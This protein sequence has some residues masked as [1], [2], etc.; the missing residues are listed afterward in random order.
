[1]QN[2]PMLKRRTLDDA[3]TIKME[4]T[5]LNEL[6]QLKSQHGFDYPEWV[7]AMVREKLPEVAKKLKNTA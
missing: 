2:L 5:L 4:K 6:R 3:M 7:R 1:M